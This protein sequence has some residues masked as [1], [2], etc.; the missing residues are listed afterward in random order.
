M[1]MFLCIKLLF[2]KVIHNFEEE[3]SKAFASVDDII[4]NYG[5]NALLSCQ[6]IKS[7]KT[8]DVVGKLIAESNC[9][10]VDQNHNNNDIEMSPLH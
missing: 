5:S 6:E 9:G 8:E 10:K 3:I 7:N 4:V 2:V 1:M